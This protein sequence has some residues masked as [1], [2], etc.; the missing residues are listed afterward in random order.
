MST[1]NRQ[2]FHMKSIVFKSTCTLGVHTKNGTESITFLKGSEHPVIQHRWAPSDEIQDEHRIFHL[3][4]ND[5][6][7]KLGLFDE[8]VQS[9]IEC[10]YLPC[11]NAADNNCY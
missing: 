9:L 5:Q 6:T 7:I 11:D 2:F 4:V 3:R 1:S 10:K 8:N